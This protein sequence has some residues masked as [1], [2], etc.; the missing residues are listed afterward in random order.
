[1]NLQNKVVLI[2]GGARRGGRCLVENFASRGARI[3]FTYRTSKR[4][5]EL[6][7]K[8]LQENDTAP[9]F[10]RP[11][12]GNLTHVKNILADL[13]KKWGGVDVLINNASDF[14]RT[15]FEKITEKDW[16]H[17]MEVNLKGTFLFAWQAGLMMK[18]RGFGKIVNIADW[19]GERPYK[20]YLPYCV[21]KSGVIGLTKALARELAPEVCV[22]AISPGPVLPLEGSTGTD[23]KKLI[24][25]L[26]LKK[27]GSPQDIAEATLFLVE[28]TDFATGAVLPVD[29]G[30]MIQ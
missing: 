18:K 4:D 3:A 23:Q 6:L 1:M 17:F 2:T 21:S 10:Y 27:I 28:R 24:E 19:A 25:N 12:S 14:Y 16:D 30:R 26:P 29:G 8:H 15:P 22:N 9:L 5:A 7:V 13:K 20:N 11:E